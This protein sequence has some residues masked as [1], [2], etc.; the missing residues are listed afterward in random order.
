[1]ELLIVLEMAQIF[2][3]TYIDNDSEMSYAVEIP[4]QGSSSVNMAGD[5]T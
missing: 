1:M 4:N 2:V 5:A 3:V